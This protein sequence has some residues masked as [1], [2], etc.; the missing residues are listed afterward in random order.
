MTDAPRDLRFEASV[1]PGRRGDADPSRIAGRGID[2]VPSPNGEIRA[3]IDLAACVRL[4]EEGYEVRL[5][6]VRP[7]QPLD[8][9]LV[10]TDDEVRALIGER[11]R[12]AGRREQS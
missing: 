5:H 7:V 3:L 1:H 9:A 6:G 10:A 11:M 4:L 2:R 12:L 8:P